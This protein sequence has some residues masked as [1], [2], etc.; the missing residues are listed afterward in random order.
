MGVITERL[1]EQSLRTMLFADD[2]VL[3]D[4]TREGLE[5]KLER[6]REEL[7]I[8]VLKISKTKA[9]YMCCNPQYQLDDIYLL[10]EIV[11]WTEKFKYL[12][13]YVEE[14]AELQIEVNSRIQ[15]G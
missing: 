8:R 13:S 12:G 9:E 5:V 3:C 1:R 14:T 6:W 4:E 15:A 10:G 7:E 2:I 11:N